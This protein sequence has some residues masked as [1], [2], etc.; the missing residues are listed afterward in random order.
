MIDTAKRKEKEKLISH[1]KAEM[2]SML[3]KRQQVR[4]VISARR[5]EKETIKRTLNE[6]AANYAQMVAHYKKVGVPSEKP[7]GE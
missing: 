5:A 4:D 6:Q 1:H 2:D 3:T 7:S